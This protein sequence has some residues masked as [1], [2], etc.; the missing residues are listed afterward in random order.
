[1]NLRETSVKEYPEGSVSKYTE[2][3]TYVPFRDAILLQLNS[4]KD[5][6]ADVIIGK[7]AIS[8]Q[9][10]TTTFECSWLPTISYVQME[11]SSGFGYP[12]APIG[13]YK[14]LKQDEPSMMLWALI[15]AI[16]G[17]KDL[18]QAI[19][20]KKNS[21]DKDGWEGH[22][23]THVCGKYARYADMKCPR[24]TPFSVSN[25]RTVE[26]MLKHVK[27]AMPTELVDSHSMALFD[28]GADFFKFNI[29]YW[30]KLFNSDDHPSICIV[31]N[32]E[33]ATEDMLKEKDVIIVVDTDEDTVSNTMEKVRDNDG[34]WDDGYGSTYEARVVIGTY[35][36]MNSKPGQFEGVRWARHGN[37]FGKYWTQERNNASCEIMTHANGVGYNVA[38]PQVAT[39]IVYVKIDSPQMDQYKLDFFHP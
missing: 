17:C 5:I 11:D 22:A 13:K 27:N 34:R 37:G 35:A 2:C 6:K 32:L 23:L 12:L 33:E 7:D 21:F 1:M 28:G 19:T 38:C 3:S 8:D 29:S 15:G 24:G 4:S 26:S 36:K 30:E 31:P 10:L 9:N 18:Y 25:S 14:C 39:V 16:V 20:K